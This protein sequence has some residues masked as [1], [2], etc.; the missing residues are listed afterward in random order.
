MLRLSLHLFGREVF[1]AEAEREAVEEPNMDLS[2]SI[3]AYEDHPELV[4]AVT[5]YLL[6]A[7]G[8]AYSQ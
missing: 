1:H 4:E 5:D 7:A 6:A 8:N 2:G 3:I